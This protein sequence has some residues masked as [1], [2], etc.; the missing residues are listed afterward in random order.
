MAITQTLAADHARLKARVADTASAVPAMKLPLRRPALRPRGHRRI[1]GS[2]PRHRAAAGGASRG[3]RRDELRHRL[4]HLGQRVA[5]GHVDGRPGHRAPLRERARASAAGVLA[6]QRSALRRS[7]RAP[8]SRSSGSALNGPDVPGCSTSCGRHGRD[9]D[10]VLFF[11]YPLRAV[12]VRAAAGRRSRRAGADR[13][14]RSADP[15]TRSSRRSSGCPRAYLFLT[16]EEEAMVGLR[17]RASCRRRPSS[18]SGIDPVPD[19]ADRS[20]AL[21]A[22]GIAA[23]ISSLYLGRVDRNKG[24]DALIRHYAAYADD[25]RRRGAAADPG[26]PV[27]LQLPAQPGLVRSAAS[28]TRRGRAAA[29]ARALVD[30]V[31][32]REP[33]P[34]AARGVEPRARRRW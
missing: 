25:G 6:P 26:R 3:Q 30:A 5:A 31:A 21:D 13:G 32:V 10:R 16:P 11:T 28:T 17:A 7:A 33:E 27:E 8:R 12:V 34:R 1:G 24:C 15:S 22:L 18:A 4:R 29:H 14:A 23:A 9:Y 2:V 19:R 20:A